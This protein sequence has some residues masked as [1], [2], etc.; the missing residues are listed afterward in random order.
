MKLL[1]SCLYLSALLCLIFYMYKTK[2]RNKRVFFFCSSTHR[3]FCLFPFVD[4]F[5][6]GRHGRVRLFL[7]A[8]TAT[9]VERRTEPNSQNSDHT[10]E[11]H[12][13][14]PRAD[15]RHEHVYEEER[16]RGILL[17][18]DF[19]DLRAGSNLAAVRRHRRTE[20]E[21]AVGEDRGVDQGENTE[22]RGHGKP[23]ERERTR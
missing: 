3:L 5:L 10:D 1:S 15:D 20:F 12:E 8:A 22:E 7:V 11:E 14:E 23:R 16:H 2:K 9:P 13:L 6:Q 19:V 18:E 17:E 4:D 21:K